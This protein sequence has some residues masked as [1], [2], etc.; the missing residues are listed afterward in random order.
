M[1]GHAGVSISHPARDALRLVDYV[2][3]GGGF[4]SRLMK[5]VRSKG[6]K[7]YGISSAFYAHQADGV[8]RVRS[9]T[10]NAEIEAEREW[11]TRDK[12]PRTGRPTLRSMRSTHLS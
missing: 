9:S 6:G 1:L 8:F 4:S 2:L 11:Q 5:E 10:R 12:D 3:G 7:T